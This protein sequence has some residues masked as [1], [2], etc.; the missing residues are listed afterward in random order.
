MQSYAKTKRSNFQIFSSD[1]TLLCASS[2]HGTIHVFSVED[3]KKNKQSSLLSST[4]FLGA[5][6]S[7]VSMT[8]NGNNDIRGVTDY[9]LVINVRAICGRHVTWNAPHA[10]YNF[11]HA[12]TAAAVMTRML[13]KYARDVHTSFTRNPLS[14]IL[15]YSKQTEQ[16][17]IYVCRVTH[18]LAD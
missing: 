6:K 17:L 15:I 5:G 10:A 16:I 11:W 4:P 18:L 7:L 3:P 13:N 12:Y 8:L 1:S 14:L 9:Q 2:S